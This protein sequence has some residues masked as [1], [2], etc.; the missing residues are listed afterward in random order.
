MYNRID[1]GKMSTLEQ[2]HVLGCLNESQVK[3]VGRIRRFINPC[4][5]GSLAIVLMLAEQVA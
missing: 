5:A 1:P 4:F 3:I 2:N